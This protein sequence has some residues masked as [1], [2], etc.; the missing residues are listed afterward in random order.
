MGTMTQQEDVGKER[1]GELQ[2][3]SVADPGQAAHTHTH[4]QM[5]DL[6]IHLWITLIISKKVMIL[7]FRAL[8]ESASTSD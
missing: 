3:R 1:S 8:A 5:A 4:K 2:A 7:I 6:P